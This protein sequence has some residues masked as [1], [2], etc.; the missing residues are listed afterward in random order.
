MKVVEAE[1]V[2]G[3]QNWIRDPIIFGILCTLLAVSEQKLKFRM[4]S[5]EESSRAGGSA[6]VGHHDRGREGNNLMMFIVKLRQ[7]S[8]KDR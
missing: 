6:E 3:V 4:M 2:A 8:G 1:D 5:A 7:G